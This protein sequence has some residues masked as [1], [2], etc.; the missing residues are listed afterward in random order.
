VLMLV[1]TVV[2]LVGEMSYKAAD[3]EALP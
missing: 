3:C 2:Y 1:E